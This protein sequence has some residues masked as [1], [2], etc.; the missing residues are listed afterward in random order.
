MPTAED[1]RSML[2]DHMTN[3]LIDPQPVDV[4]YGTHLLDR[5]IGV[6]INESLDKVIN[7]Q[8]EIFPC[9]CSFLKG[10]SWK[11]GDVCDGSCAVAS[12]KNRVIKSIMNEKKSEF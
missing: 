12:W 3:M 10:F 6:E 8:D 2:I 1:L 9:D 11:P 4:D 7:A 5:L